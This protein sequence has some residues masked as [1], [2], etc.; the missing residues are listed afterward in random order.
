MPDT[1]VFY[2]DL[3]LGEH[4]AYV[5]ALHGV[6]D[7]AARIESLLD[8]LGLAEWE[9]GIASEFSKGM[10]QKASVALALVR[11][12]SVLLADEP[13]DGL[14]PPSRDV[15]FELLSEAR[16]GGAAIVVS[17]H[18]PDVIAAAGRC[19][20]IRDGRLAYDGAPEA[21]AIA[22]FFERSAEADWPAELGEAS[23][24]PTRSATRSM[25]VR[26]LTMIDIDCWKVSWSMSSAPI[27]SRVRAQ[28]I[29]SAIDG[30]FFKS[31]A[32]TIRITSTRRVASASGE[33]G[34]MQADDLDLALEL[35]VV[36]PE[37]EAAALQR[38]GQLARVVRGED[39]DRHRRR[40]DLAELGDRDLEVGEQLEQHRL[41]LLV[42]LVD[43]VDQQDDGLG[44]GDRLHQRSLEQ[45]LLAED[46]AVDILPAVLAAGL[47]PE[48]L[49]AVVPLVE[50]LRLV[51]PLVALQAD[52]VAACGARERLGQLGLADAGRAL[53]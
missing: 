39:D 13:F 18:R 33:V 16:A 4:L 22:E 23:F 53:D 30:G 42:G 36:E 45:E 2:E 29:D 17:T 31:R 5:A 40:R 48:Q 21:E 49:L 37:V 25:S 43:L 24:T 12:F 38:L 14:D 3:S 1:P 20:A 50:R 27:S 6:G 7:P 52:Q 8:R 10:R 11:P 9:D 28:S 19:V 34:G 47:D 44:A 51:E 46:V 26:C 15:L 41:E 35:G 32:R